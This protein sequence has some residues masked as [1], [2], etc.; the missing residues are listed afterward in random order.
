LI[1]MT[2]P[3]DLMEQPHPN[4][5]SN[6]WAING[7]K[8]ASGNPILCSD[9][10]LGLTLPSIW[11][12]VHIN[13]PEINAYGVSLPSEPGILIG[14]N[15]HIAWA[16]TNVGHDVLDWYQIKWVD[17]SKT[18]YHFDG[19]VKEVDIRFDTIYVKGMEPVIEA[20]KYTVWGPVVYEDSS[21]LYYDLAMR[22]VA[23]DKPKKKDF[24]DLGTFWK[25][26]AAKNHQEYL[27]AL[28]GYDSPAQN[29][30][31]A[32]TEGDI[33]ITVN[34]NLPVKRN[35]QGRFV[36][37]GSRS[38]NGWNGFIP[39]DQIPQVLNPE[40][41]FIASSNQH[42]TDEDYPYYY[43]AGFDDYRG[44]MVN[45]RLDSME[46]I[47]I[48]D[49]MEMQNSSFG[50]YAKEALAIILPMLDRRDL[51][52][53]EKEALAALESWDYYYRS[54][55]L[56]PVILD[57]IKDSIY[58]KTFDELI[59]YNQKARIAW[60]ESWRLL[61]LLEQHPNH[62]IFDHQRTKAPETALDIV[63]QAF[64]E[65]VASI[66]EEMT[67]RKHNRPAVNHMANIP[68]FGRTN[69]DINGDGNSI[70]AISGDH[71]PSWRMIV[72]LGQPIKAYGVYPG[73]Q[74]G[75][76]GSR[77]FDQMVDQWAKGDYNELVFPKDKAG[78]SKEETLFS[79]NFKN[80]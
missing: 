35:Q 50:L 37:D 56:A 41:G 73:G 79:M 71:G 47:T 2:F 18:Q 27:A 64:Q 61:E 13:T 40:R 57:V 74:S 42:S 65:A 76:P 62:P 67:W 26:K 25:L 78:M 39:R 36:Q 10:H 49:M 30:A 22:W 29:F 51:D 80:K 21:A 66:P 16:E 11:Y 24:Y 1:G 72:E 9:P 14:F 53:K 43:N 28:S 59:A 45:A 58:Q 52:T 33:A 4:N 46:Q 5:G 60:P 32:S 68:A 54:E 38:E 63:N 12:E 70:N 6:N 15:D 17:D 55:E 31:F 44:R 23:L 8:S 7:E 19:Q 20:T 3:Y 48:E 77:F 34:G 75:N 69:L